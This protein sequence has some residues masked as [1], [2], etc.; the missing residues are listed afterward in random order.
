LAELRARRDDERV[1]ALLARID[2]AAR[3]SENLMPL[4]VEAVGNDVTLGEV[5]DVL[6]GVWGEYRPVTSI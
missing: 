2:S 4:F 5:C 6:R 3:G 1:N